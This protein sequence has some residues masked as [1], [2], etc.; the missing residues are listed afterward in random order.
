MG[1][2]AQERTCFPSHDDEL[3]HDEPRHENLMYKE[4]N[5]CEGRVHDAAL[6]LG[7]H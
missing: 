4:D 7:C 1:L 2:A 3:S 5:A 6:S